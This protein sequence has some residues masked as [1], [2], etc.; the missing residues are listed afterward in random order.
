MGSILHSK[1]ILITHSDNWRSESNERVW[2]MNYKYNHFSAHDK[3]EKWY[4]HNVW[5]INQWKT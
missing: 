2:S 3:H 1:E 4:R 5:C